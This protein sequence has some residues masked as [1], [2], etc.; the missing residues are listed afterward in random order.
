MVECPSVSRRLLLATARTRAADIDR[1]L[2]RRVPDAVARAVAV[3]S[4][5]LGAN[6]RGSKLTCLQCVWVR[7]AMCPT[8]GGVLR[9]CIECCRHRE[10]QN[11]Y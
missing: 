9:V 8:G 5:M 2:W 7:R 6:L 11:S 4:V 10:M 3:G 1:Q